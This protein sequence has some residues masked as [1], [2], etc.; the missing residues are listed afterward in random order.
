[1]FIICGAVPFLFSLQ[2]KE[3]HAR[4]HISHHLGPVHP[5]YNPYFSACFFNRNSVFLSQQI[6]QPCFS[7]GL[8]AQPTMFFQLVSVLKLTSSA[9]KDTLLTVKMLGILTILLQSMNQPCL[10]MLA[11]ERD[12]LPTNRSFQFVDPTTN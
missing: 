1:V 4:V 6:S 10:L 5:A 7:A 9:E 2:I 11:L 12:G 8:S 3:A